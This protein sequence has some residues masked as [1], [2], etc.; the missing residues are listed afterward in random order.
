M[1]VSY[2]RWSHLVAGVKSCLKEINVRA[3]I[4]DNTVN[5]L[6]TYIKPSTSGGCVH[7]IY[8]L[9]SWNTELFMVNLMW[10]LAKSLIP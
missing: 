1:P 10:P 2:S 8:I 3:V 7:L 5:K 4:R 6:C 9:F